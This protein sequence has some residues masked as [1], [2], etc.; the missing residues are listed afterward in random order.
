VNLYRDGPFFVTGITDASGL[1]FLDIGSGAV[2]HD[3][4][5]QFVLPSGLQFSPADQG[6]DA[7]DSD[8]VDA[9]TGRTAI[10][11]GFAFPFPNGPILTVDAG[12]FPTT[13][14]PEPG[15]LSLIAAALV[16]LARC[17]GIRRRFS[18]TE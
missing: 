2:S 9:L 12:M 8:V 10:I 11:P 5:V 16:G 4:V 7:L 18:R 14:V 3:W 6:N 13:T 17:A 15:T 1:Y